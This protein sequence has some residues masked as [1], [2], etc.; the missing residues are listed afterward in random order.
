VTITLVILNIIAFGFQ[1]YAGRFHPAFPVDDYFALSLD[2]LRHHYFWQLLTFQF[3]HGGFLHIILNLWG[4]FIF[5]RVVEFTL[6]K[7]RML[8]LYLLSGAI[9]GLVQMLGAWLLPNLFGTPGVVGA[10]AGVF[11][12]VA[13]FAVLYPNQKLYLLLFLIIPLRMRASTLIWLSV[14]FSVFGIFLPWIGPHL[15]HAIGLQL[16]GLMGNWAHAAHLGGIA[17]GAWLTWKL[18]RNRRRTVPPVLRQPEVKSTLNI[19]PAS[20]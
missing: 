15:P 18:L 5:G 10:S 4:L 3:M 14:A 8:Q 1:L 11:G 2:G 9:G 19:N 13:A 20:D 16:D 6:G 17:T 12:L 7:R